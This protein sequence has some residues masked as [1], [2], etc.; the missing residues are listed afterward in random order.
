[1]AIAH[2]LSSLYLP[3]ILPTTA[4]FLHR[5]QLT[6]LVMLNKLRQNER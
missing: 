3:T 4:F 5:N 6:T 1:M 2:P